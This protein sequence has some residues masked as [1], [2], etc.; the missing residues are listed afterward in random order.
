M[1]EN[2]IRLHLQAINM[3]LCKLIII[4]F[5]H[6]TL[7]TL[8]LSYPKHT[9]QLPNHPSNWICTVHITVATFANYTSSDITERFLASNREKILPTVGT[10]LN[11]SVPIAPVNFFFEP[12]T[13]SVLIDATINGASYVFQ[14]RRVYR[15]FRGNEYVYRGWRHSLIFRYIRCLL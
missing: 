5:C 6:L 15:Y 2:K 8:Q 10:L 7:A 4:L 1:F 3:Y 12:C 14:G 9:F 13:I 11:R